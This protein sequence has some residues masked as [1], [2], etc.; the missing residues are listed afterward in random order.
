MAACLPDPA[1]RRFTYLSHPRFTH[2]IP[3]VSGSTTLSDGCLPCAAAGAARPEGGVTGFT[4]RETSRSAYMALAL[5]S[6]RLPSAASPGCHAFPHSPHIAAFR[7]RTA[8]RRHP[9]SEIERRVWSPAEEALRGGE[10][11]RILPLPN[12]TQPG[13]GWHVAASREYADVCMCSGAD[14]CGI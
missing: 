12:V 3:L 4:K 9:H 6:G 10:R 1:G 8:S 14:G 11:G 2:R 5:A 7:R 13:L